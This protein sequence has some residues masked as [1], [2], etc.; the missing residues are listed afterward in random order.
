M[1]EAAQGNEKMPRGESAFEKAR[2]RAIAA[3]ALEGAR[4]LAKLLVEIVVEFA[5]SD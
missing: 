4:R 1:K 2:K 5:D 3:A